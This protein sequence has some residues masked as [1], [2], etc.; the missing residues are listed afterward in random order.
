MSTM[1]V[2]IVESKTPGTAQLTIISDDPKENSV[3]VGALS[4]RIQKADA[5]ANAILDK[6]PELYSLI[7]F[8]ADIAF[9]HLDDITTIDL[10]IY[11]NQHPYI[12]EKNLKLTNNYMISFEMW[13]SSR[14]PKMNPWIEKWDSIWNDADLSYCEKLMKGLKEREYVDLGEADKDVRDKLPKACPKVFYHMP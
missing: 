10:A 2:D 4:S 14:F 5:A 8:I 7:E 12:I 9:S 3:L 6:N 11:L 13:V 1:S